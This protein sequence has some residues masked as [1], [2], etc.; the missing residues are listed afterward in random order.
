[1]MQAFREVFYNFGSDTSIHGFT[2]IAGFNR[3]FLGRIF[4]SIALAISAAFLVYNIQISYEKWQNNPTIVVKTNI[5]NLREIPMPAVTICP[6]IF[7]KNKMANFTDF[8]IKYHTTDMSLPVDISSTEANY[9]VANFQVYYSISSLIKD[10]KKYLQRLPQVTDKNIIK[11]H[12]ESSLKV[13]ELLKVC[14][15]KE[16]HTRCENLYKKILTDRGFCYSFNMQGFNTIFN[17]E[18]ISD[19]FHSYKRTKIAKNHLTPGFFNATKFFNDAEDEVQWTLEKGFIADHDDDVV[20][21]TAIKRATFSA[22]I[23]LTEEDQRNIFSS[24][25]KCFLYSIHLPNEIPNPFHHDNQ[26]KFNEVESVVL[27][28]KMFKTNENLRGYSPEIRGCFFEGE[29]KLIFFKSYTKA[30][31]EFE[32][33]ANETLKACGCVKFS[34]PRDN[35]TKVCDEN[36][37]DCYFDVWKNFPKNQQ[38]SQPCDCLKPCTD[39]KYSIAYE[40]TSA[41]DDASLLVMEFREH[42]IEEEESYSAHTIH[43]C[44]LPLAASKL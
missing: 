43:V 4:W 20:P 7:A 31:C 44:K 33:L 6:T 11:L 27:T 25:L 2:F 35:N 5:G 14:F 29:K 38:K 10:L 1:M 17:A 9:F 42:Q 16:Q 8:Y 12:D 30:N 32:C 39:I 28:A 34:M 24:Y 37:A 21:I 36:E 23:E 18:I 26:I 40:D 13:E 19:D 3:N 41:Y 22:Q 15:Y